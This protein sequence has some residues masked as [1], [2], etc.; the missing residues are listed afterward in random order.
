MGKKYGVCLALTLTIVSCV[1]L[2]KALESL[3]TNHMKAHCDKLLTKAKRE[4]RSAAAVSN[5]QQRLQHYA[6][7]TALLSVYYVLS[8]KHN[9]PLQIKYTTLSHQCTQGQQRAIAAASKRA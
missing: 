9:L 4:I 7:G 6:N 3:R 8:K 5:V 2:F 1:M